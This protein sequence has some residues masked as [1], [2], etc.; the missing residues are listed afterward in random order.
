[1]RA[2]NIKGKPT[3]VIFDVSDYSKSYGKYDAT[4]N[5]VFYASDVASSAVRKKVNTEF[6]EM[7]HMRQAENFKRKFNKEITEKN[8]QEYL[9]FTCSEAKKFLDSKGINRYNVGKIS[10]YAR[11]SYFRGRYDET[12]AEYKTLIKES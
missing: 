12:E 8:R 10:V 7:W 2:W 4:T 6:H 11:N 5:T 1:M 9:D 3:I